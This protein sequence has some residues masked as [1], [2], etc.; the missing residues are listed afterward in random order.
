MEAWPEREVDRGDNARSDRGG[1]RHVGVVGELKDGR[2]FRNVRAVGVNVVE[3][4]GRAED[5]DQIVVRQ[6]TN[7]AAADAGERP[8]KQWMVLGETA[9]RGQSARE[10]L[11]LDPL[12]QLRHERAA[13]VAID[14]GADDERREAT[15]V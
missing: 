9:A 15:R 2:A 6:C 1:R 5:D 13:V 4:R 7:D 8:G 12:G 11:R 10:N 3:K 14:L